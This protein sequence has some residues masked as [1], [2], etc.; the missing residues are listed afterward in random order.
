MAGIRL[1]FRMA[2]GGDA[3]L[4]I[5]VIDRDVRRVRR[6]RILPH[7]HQAKLVGR[8]QSR[9]LQGPVARNLGLRVSGRGEQR[10]ERGEQPDCETAC[11]ARYNEVT[12]ARLAL[13]NSRKRGRTMH[14]RRQGIAGL[15]TGWRLG[16]KG[17]GT[18]S[19]GRA[20][21]LKSGRQ[22][23]MRGPAGVRDRAERL[24][25]V[26]MAGAEHRVS[27]QESPGA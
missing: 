7:E 4:H 26:P 14:M 15:K 25:A 21:T 19:D 9:R 20:A 3:A 8:T 5:R 24:N 23:P 12:H 16:R 10:D 18:R 22:R 2:D 1:D 11:G 17:T 6:Q 27:D 13:M